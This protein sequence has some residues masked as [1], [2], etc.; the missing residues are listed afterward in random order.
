[1]ASLPHG[2]PHVQAF[3]EVCQHD[4]RCQRQSCDAVLKAGTFRYYVLSDIQGIG[5]WVC[6]DCHAY[7]ENKARTSSLSLSSAPLVI[8]D[9][10]GNQA[11]TMR[12]I[13]RSRAA[14]IQNSDRNQDNNREG[15]QRV[16]NVDINSIRNMVN[17]AQR[18]GKTINNPIC[19]TLT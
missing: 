3:T 16:G 15:I 14:S 11:T 18:K 7:Y 13:E 4:Q 6:K 19:Q 9:T 5:R 1:M 10:L 8:M 17:A 12:R 2:A